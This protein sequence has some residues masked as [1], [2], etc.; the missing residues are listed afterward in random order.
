MERKTKRMDALAATGPAVRKEKKRTEE[1]K[2]VICSTYGL[3]ERLLARCE[4]IGLKK[5]E[6]IDTFRMHATMQWQ[7]GVAVGH[8]RPRLILANHRH[9]PYTR[10]KLHRFADY[11]KIK[12]C[13]VG[14]LTAT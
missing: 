8:P 1:L 13:K 7:G 12:T 14:D 4:L 11:I 3:T 6:P 10:R 5:P 2:A 9:L